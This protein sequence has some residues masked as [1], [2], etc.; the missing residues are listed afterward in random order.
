MNVEDIKNDITVTNH[1]T[2]PFKFD[3]FDPLNNNDFFH[4]RVHLLG[5]WNGK[6]HDTIKNYF[7]CTY[8]KSKYH[9]QISKGST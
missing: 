9:N 7:I 6:N 2:D 4:L 1:K 3:Y 5:P 8:L